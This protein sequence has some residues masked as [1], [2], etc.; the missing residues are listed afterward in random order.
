MAVVYFPP[1]SAVYVHAVRLTALLN[2][3]LF[4]DKCVQPQYVKE[5]IAKRPVLRRSTGT[6]V[7]RSLNPLIVAQGGQVDSR[8]VGKQASM[9]LAQGPG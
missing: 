5:V 4:S 3:A 9:V 8:L 7:F 1:A 6:P 2:P